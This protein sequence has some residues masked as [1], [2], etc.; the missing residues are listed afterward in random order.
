MTTVTVIGAGGEE[1]KLQFTSSA[2]AVLAQQLAGQVTA[3]VKSGALVPFEY[4]GDPVVPP[5]PL[6][7]DGEFVQQKPGLAI[8]P[9][10]Y[11]AIVVNTHNS[12]VFGGGAPNEIVLSG[13][14]GLTFFTGAGSGT[15]A[16]GGGHNLIVEPTVGGGNWL[17]TTGNGSDTILALSGS[18][19]IAAG[20]GHNRIF[21]GSGDNLVNSLGA[22]TIS[23]S[24]GGS[25][26]INALGHDGDM[27]FGGTAHFTFVGGAGRSSVLG[28]SGSETVFGGSGGGVF[29]GGGAGNNVIQGGSGAATMVGGGDGD[30][31][32][33]AGR[34]GDVLR[35]GA[36]NETLSA[37]LSTGHD[38]LF[39]GPG[40]DSLI[41]GPGAAT[42][43]GGSGSAT[44]TAGAGRDVF[45]FVKGEAGGTDLVQG[46]AGGPDGDK[47]ALVGYGPHAVQDAL[48]TQQHAGGATTLTL[49]DGTT[50]TFSHVASLNTS[51]FV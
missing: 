10:D 4:T 11:T 45:A 15:I 6:G 31:L 22:D 33:A 44:L 9:A 8:L 35:A 36:G 7:T 23:I 42:L 34:M 5:A 24:G 46:F 49:P 47:V 51:N 12:S 39:A 19:T 20:A 1:I 37:V 38:Q 43:Y 27:V 16:A 32:F 26:T 18:N 14:D 50:I 25:D 41:A 29:V 28:Q 21:L 40:S 2:N 13:N 17:I 48:S 3:G 30:Q